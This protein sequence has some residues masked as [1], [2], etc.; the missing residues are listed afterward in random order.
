MLCR[1]CHRLEETSSAARRPG[2]PDLMPAGKSYGTKAE[3]KQYEAKRRAMIV[4]PK[5]TYVDAEKLRRGHCLQCERPVTVATAFAFDFDH[6]DPMTKMKGEETLAGTN[7]GVG[8]LAHNITKVA[9]LAKI[10]GVL[11]AE[12]A[13]CDLLCTNCHHRK[14]WGYPMRA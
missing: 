9:S 2:D 12:M 5:Q 7:G 6:R 10:K 8:G 11:D 3:V 14:T 13:K 1:F 4:Y